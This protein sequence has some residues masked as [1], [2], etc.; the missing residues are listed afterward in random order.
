MLHLRDNGVRTIFGY[1]GSSVSHL[2]D[3]LH[4]IKE[5]MYVQNNH[6]QASA[7]SANAYSQISGG[8]GVALSCSGPGATNLVTGIANA[9]FDSIPCVFITG[10]VGL[11]GIKSHPLIRQH[12][13]QETNIV[14]IVKPITKFAVT[15]MNPEEIRFN[16]EKALYLAQE[17]RPGSV[18]ID[19]PHDVQT[20]DINPQTLSNFFASAD[21]KNLATCY[22]DIDYKIVNEIYQLLTNA[23]R[24]VLLLGGG[25]S[26]LKGTGLIERFISKCHIPVVASL[27]GLDIFSHHHECYSGF[28]G[29]YGNRY[30]NFCVACSDVLLVLGSR[31]DT[32]QTGPDIK[33]FA[34][35]SKIIRVDID[36]HELKRIDRNKFDIHCDVSMF[37]EKMVKNAGKDQFFAKQW[38]QLIDTWKR[39]YPSG[40]QENSGYVNPNEII[41]ALDDYLT[42]N[43]IICCD[44]GL[45]QMYVAQSI[46][47]NGK[48]SLLS[49]GGHG[50]MGYSLPA[51]IGAYFV[52]MDRQIISIVGDGGIQ[53][54]SQE[55]HTIVKEKI[56]VKIIIMNNSSLGMIRSYQEKALEGR[57]YGS[58]DGFSSPDYHKIADAYG[59]R[60]F[61]IASMSDFKDNAFELATI[62]PCIFE[63]LLDPHPQINPGPA[64]KR[65]V[66][67]QFPLIDREEYQ[68]IMN[69]I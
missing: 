57:T 37:M 66:E 48:R 6:E 49:S 4:K 33:Q 54:N 47:L 29:A 5:L 16:L 64:Y 19:I 24:P 39:K 1:Q 13:F 53:I 51:A 63:V 35:N 32:M 17:G 41:S 67:D 21:Y 59:L 27:K 55:L 52:S 58:V 50:A 69:L 42:E 60:Y 8:L 10:Q 38:L 11:A 43:A 23:K 20:A 62:E 2:I 56:P 7:F 3:S 14:S 22:D 61:K 44:V 40:I 65:P 68:Q 12:G 26:H 30:A 46:R 15:I 31:L 45:N 18:L 9:Y 28:I 25:S 36:I 34:R